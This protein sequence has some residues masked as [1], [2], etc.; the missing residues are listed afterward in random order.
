MVLYIY[1]REK[2]REMYDVSQARADEERT[3][4]TLITRARCFFF[5]TGGTFFYSL[6]MWSFIASRDFY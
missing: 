2:E 1:S 6:S 3:R 5:F 4:A